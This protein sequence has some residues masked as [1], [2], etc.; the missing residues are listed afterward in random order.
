[1][2]KK[3]NN[4]TKNNKNKKIEQEDLKSLI[5]K[6]LVESRNKIINM[7]VNDYKFD[8]NK[9]LQI[10][11]SVYTSTRSK[12]RERYTF[13]EPF[14][15]FGNNDNNKYKTSINDYPDFV[16][17]SWIALTV[18]FYQSLGDTMGYYNGNWEFNYGDVR[19]GPDYVN[20][21]IYDFISLGGVNDISMKNWM[22]SDDTIL[23]IATMDVLTNKFSDIND[24]GNKLRNAYVEAKPLIADRHPGNTTD[25][26]LEVQKHIEWD[27]LPYNSKAIGNGSAMRSGSIG[28]FFPGKQNRKKLIA[29]SVESSRITHNS[30]VAILGSITTALFTAYALEKIDINRWPNKLL[31]LLKSGIID[32]YMEKTHPDDYKN[33]Y[34]RDKI[35]Y[36]G[37]WKNY[38]DLLFSAS[39]NNPR[40]DLR[41]MKNPVQRY[42][43]LSENFSKGCDIP[44][45][46]ADDCVIMA[47]DALLRCDGVFEKLIVY[48]ILHPGDSDTVGSIAF[49]WF[50]G[51]YHSPRNE[52]LVGHLFDDLEFYDKLYDLLEKNIS[53]M[54]KVY[55]YDIY[56]DVARTY[57][58]QYINK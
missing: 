52:R 40:L 4:T 57:L 28:I 50:G 25:V 56:L 41:Y 3:K 42:K 39:S 33:S 47:Y 37:Q 13:N 22:A 11:E 53:K 1:M 17:W 54:T 6:Y 15:S 2:P 31:N 43:Y 5:E 27:K 55:Y 46:C 23:Y 18:P 10:E 7:L 24:F 30:A 14:I 19:A 45:G 36:V 16:N 35:I 51:Y 8:K 26:S 34:I 44:G 20:E 49:S 9:A 29:L 32:E 12:M 21:L 58:K 48:S 38:V